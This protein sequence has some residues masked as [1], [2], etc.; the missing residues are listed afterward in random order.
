MYLTTH[1]KATPESYLTSPFTKA[2][3]PITH[4]YVVIKLI[5]FPPP[6]IYLCI[7]LCCKMFDGTKQE[8][9]NVSNTQI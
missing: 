1:I 5:L 3:E 2:I 9:A 8:N 4:I 7:K 6:K